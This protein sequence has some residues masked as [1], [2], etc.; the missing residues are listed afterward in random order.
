MVCQKIEIGRF[1]P[2]WSPPRSRRNLLTD[3]RTRRSVSPLALVQARQCCGSGNSPFVICQKKI[4]SFSRL[5]S[6]YGRERAIWRGANLPCRDYRH[7]ADK[8]QGTRIAS[9][10]VPCQCLSDRLASFCQ[11]H[12]HR[13]SSSSLRAGSAVSS[14]FSTKACPIFFL[15]L[16]RTSVNVSF[17]L[18]P[19]QSRRTR[20]GTDW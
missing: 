9:S 3:I 19:S 13:P 7:V 12:S 17:V 2:R 15:G 5:S 16:F 4:I 18:R 10:H 8:R 14:I 1:S 6:A 20:S 11:Q